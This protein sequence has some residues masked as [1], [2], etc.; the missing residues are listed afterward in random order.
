LTSEDIL[1]PI[2][3][4]EYAGIQLLGLHSIIRN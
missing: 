4:V 2:P 1:S 3:S